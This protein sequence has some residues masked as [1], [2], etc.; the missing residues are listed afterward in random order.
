MGTGKSTVAPL[1]AARL[2][3]DFVDTDDVIVERAGMDIPA[4]FER[5]G[6]AYFRRLEAEVCVDLAAQTGFVIATGGGALMNPDTL[7]AMSATGMVVCLTA[8]VET[9][10]QRLTAGEQAGRPLADGWRELYAQRRPA[11]DVIPYQVDTSDK[12]PEQVAEEVIQ[13]WQSVFG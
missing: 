5:Q 10:E 4:I 8:D 6:E 1:V 2:G 12:S 13:Q 3:R 11:Y 9:I 7:A